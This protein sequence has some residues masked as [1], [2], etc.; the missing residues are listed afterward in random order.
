MKRASGQTGGKPTVSVLMPFRPKKIGGHARG[1]PIVGP[2][3]LPRTPRG[4]LLVAVAARGARDLV[5]EHLLRHGYQEARDF[6]C[7]T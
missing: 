2:D 5:R 3:D 4:L 1:V 7:T 6:M